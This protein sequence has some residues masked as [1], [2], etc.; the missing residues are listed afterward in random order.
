[1]VMTKAY[2]L[3]EQISITEVDDEVVLLRL[4]TGAY[5]G[6]NSVGAQLVNGLKNERTLHQICTDISSQYQIP[7]KNVNED[8]AELIEQ[9]EDEQ[10]L[11]KVEAD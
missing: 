4:D 2:R 5:Y 6:L 11:V 1:M 10:L 3:S 7:Y 9:L 8:L